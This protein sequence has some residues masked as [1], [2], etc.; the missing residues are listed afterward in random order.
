MK[1]SLKSDSW[2]NACRCEP[3][4]EVA[5]WQ[6]QLVMLQWLLGDPPS[7]RVLVSCRH[8]A[9]VLKPHARNPGFTRYCCGFRRCARLTHRDTNRPLLRPTPA[10]STELVTMAVGGYVAW[11]ITM[12]TCFPIWANG[13]TH[14]LWQLIKR[15]GS[16]ASPPP[17][18]QSARSKTCWR[19]HC[20][21]AVGIDVAGHRQQRHCHGQW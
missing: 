11:A 1:R 16:S 8:I 20:N 4:N 14:I 2:C 6:T 13:L 18:S 5:A 3:I 19:H 10:R 17:I 9:S 15:C 7:S 21:A 12:I